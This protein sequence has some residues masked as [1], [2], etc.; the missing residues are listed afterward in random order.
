MVNLIQPAMPER[1]REHEL[2]GEPGRG[3]VFNHLDKHFGHQSRAGLF[4]SFG[5]FLPECNTRAEFVHEGTSSSLDACHHIRRVKGDQPG[6]DVDCSGLRHVSMFNKRELRRA[7]SH[8]NIEDRLVLA[9]REI[10]GAG[11]VG[12]EERLVV[13]TRRRADEFAGI[14][15]KIRD[16]RLGVLLLEGLAGDD[17][18]SRV[19]I[20][21]LQAGLSIGIGNE[22]LHSLEVDQGAGKIRGQHDLGTEQDLSFHDFEA[23]R[24]RRPLPS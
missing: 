14:L 11:T 1:R 16:D 21:R 20:V 12:G 18:R 10:D 2:P 17:D 5:D 3:A 7:A 13:V 8:V 6:S 15:R 9:L 22:V 19:D 24:E 23:P 4:V